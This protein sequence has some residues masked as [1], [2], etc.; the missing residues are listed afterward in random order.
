VFVLPF[1]VQRQ[2]LREIISS[3]PVANGSVVV[4]LA[5]LDFAATGKVDIDVRN[6]LVRRGAQLNMTSD[7][8]ARAIGPGLVEEDI[9]SH[10]TFFTS[11][12]RDPLR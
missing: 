3:R 9:Q 6:G 5:N 12:S 4:M 1:C 10:R 11:A 8:R 7:S 2:M